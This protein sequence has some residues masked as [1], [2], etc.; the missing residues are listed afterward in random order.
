VSGTI[1][2]AQA[3]AAYGVLDSEPDRHL[4]FLFDWEAT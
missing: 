1:T 3:P 4:T 2:P